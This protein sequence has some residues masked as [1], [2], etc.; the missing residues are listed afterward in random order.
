MI[1]AIAV[2]TGFQF[3]DEGAPKEQLLNYLRE[4]RMLLVLDNF[5]Q[6][7][8][9][10]TSKQTTEVRALVAEILMT[11]PGIKLLIT[12]REGLNLQQEWLHPVEG[13]S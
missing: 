8:V 5:E 9:L 12:S 11:A 3:H 13:M 6:L 4:K 1:S 2:S 10:P 7:L